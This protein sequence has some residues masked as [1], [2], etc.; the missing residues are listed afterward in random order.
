M[1]P[2]GP[3]AWWALCAAIGAACLIAWQL[4]VDAQLALRWRASTWLQQPWTLWTAALSHV[5]A[6]HLGLNLLSL[7]CLCLIGAQ[8][9]AGAREAL[10]LAIAWPLSHLALLLW[11]SVQ[12]YTGLS[13][14]NHALAVIIAARCAMNFV[15]T[16]RLQ[17]IGC[18]LAL[19]VIVKLIWE[20]AWSEPLRADASWG[21]T[22]VQAA[23][24]SGFVIGLLA[25]G[26]LY[27]AR[28][29]RTSSVVE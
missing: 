17:V 11:P 23:H 1:M 22:V 6:A 19:L 5:N 10:A 28:I 29:L 20:S 18:L 7:L 14:L 3:L 24:L 8:A 25:A 16:K 26:V 12:L 27:V 15:A 4:P 9:G 21:F 2:R 13:G